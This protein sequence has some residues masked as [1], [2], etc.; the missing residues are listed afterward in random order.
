ML[1][2]NLRRSVLGSVVLSFSLSAIALP[3]LASAAQPS[4]AQEP[5]SKFSGTVVDAEGKPIAGAFTSSATLG[6]TGST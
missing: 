4:Y 5:Q 3:L 2:P 1:I 6:F